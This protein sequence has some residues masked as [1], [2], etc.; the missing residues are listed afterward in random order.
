MLY[1]HKLFESQHKFIEEVTE[2]MVDINDEEKDNQCNN[3]K[4]NIRRISSLI[5]IISRPFF[6]LIDVFSPLFCIILYTQLIICACYIPVILSPLDFNHFSTLLETLTLQCCYCIPECKYV[7]PD[8]YISTVLAIFMP[9]TRL[10]DAKKSP[11]CSC[12]KNISLIMN[13][14]YLF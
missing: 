9:I 1:V 11:S 8:I 13:L 2:Q 7:G 5:N 6:K 4:S 12:L 14:S 3:K 10:S